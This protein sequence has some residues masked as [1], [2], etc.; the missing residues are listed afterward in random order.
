V[1]I[2]IGVIFVLGGAVGLWRW[3]THRDLDF[4]RGRWIMSIDEFETPTTRQRMCDDIIENHLKIGMTEAE[5]L[6]L[7][8][9][10]SEGYSYHNML[11]FYLGPERGWFGI[12]SEWIRVELDEDGRLVEAR[13]GTD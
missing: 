4:D 8:G 7:L 10:P 1:L 6:D 9:E 5:I 3:W 2:G 11:S 13:W 12:D